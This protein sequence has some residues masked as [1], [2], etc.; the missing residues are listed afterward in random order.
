[1][2]KQWLETSHGQKFNVTVVSIIVDKQG[3]EAARE[4]KI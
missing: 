3:K 1:V 2:Q 4:S